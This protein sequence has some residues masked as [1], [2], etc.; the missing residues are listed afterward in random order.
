[1]AA[2]Y[3]F[4]ENWRKEAR[5]AE[6]CDRRQREGGKWWEEEREGWRERERETESNIEKLTNEA[7]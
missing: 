7:N 6:R 5:M 4:I 3:R 2:S 1:M